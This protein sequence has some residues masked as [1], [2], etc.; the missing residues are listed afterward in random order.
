M[1]RFKSPTTSVSGANLPPTGDGLE[2]DRTLDQVDVTAEHQP[3][4]HR[5]AAHRVGDD[6]A[7]DVLQEVAIAVLR[8]EKRPSSS[9][10]L[11]HWLCAITLRQC[12][13][14]RRRDLRQNRLHENAASEAE[15]EQEALQ[16]DPIHGLLAAESIQQVRSACSRLPRES[17]ELLQMKVVQGMSYPQ[18]AD[19]TGLSRHTVEYRITV[20]RQEFRREM[21]RAGMEAE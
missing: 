9:A 14:W 10:Q 6:A 3:V 15:T 5:I 4:L 2:G 12:A 7:D 18:I 20:A 16:R 11:R 8:S 19:A 17:A 13:L 21:V 1:K